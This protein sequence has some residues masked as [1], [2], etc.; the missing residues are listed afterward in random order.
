MI[1]LCARAFLPL[2]GVAVERSPS[3]PM[4]AVATG[5][6]AKLEL[7][8]REPPEFALPERFD[9]AAA[10]ADLVGCASPTTPREEATPTTRSRRCSAPPPKVVSSTPPTRSSPGIAG[11]RGCAW[12]NLVVLGTLSKAFSLGG[13]RVGYAITSPPLAAEP[14]LPST[15]ERVLVIGC[16]RRRGAAPSRKGAM[17]W[18]PLTAGRAELSAGLAALGWETR[19]SV[20][21]GFC[22]AESARKSPRWLSR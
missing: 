16:D 5:Q 19:P 1:D 9:E 11:R 18:W 17:R 15:G 12:P 2:G 10:E 13:I 14:P 4:Y 8:W 6:Q 20:L 7:V 3:Y 22:S 21:L